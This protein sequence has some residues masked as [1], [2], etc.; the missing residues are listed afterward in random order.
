[1]VGAWSRGCIL[2]RH[3]E[4][5]TTNAVFKAAI[6]VVDGKALIFWNK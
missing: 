6:F 5:A 4:N 2:S 1:M 3:P